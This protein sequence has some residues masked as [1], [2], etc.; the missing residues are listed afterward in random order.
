MR[1]K[2]NVCLKG[3]EVELPKIQ[4]N[5]IIY[6]PECDKTMAYSEIDYEDN[7]FWQ[8][9]DGDFDEEYGLT[10]IEIIY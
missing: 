7:I 8:I 2:C 10:P 9:V 6:C 1:L 4:N 3:P 5:I